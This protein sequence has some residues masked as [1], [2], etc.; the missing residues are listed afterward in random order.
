MLTAKLVVHIAHFDRYSG[1]AD[2]V[3]D[4]KPDHGKAATLRQACALYAY[5]WIATAWCG[6]KMLEEDKLFRAIE[7][8][9]GIG[10]TSPRFTKLHAAF[11]VQIVPSDA[12]N[13]D[14]IEGPKTADIKINWSVAEGDKKI[15]D[16]L[17]ALATEYQTPVH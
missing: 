11:L 5:P 13:D 3:S 14:N 6:P 12:S 8:S 17:A 7:G 1:K 10:D 9:I 4:F 15:K 2:R 16:F